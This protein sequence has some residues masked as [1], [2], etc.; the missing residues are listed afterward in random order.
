MSASNRALKIVA[1]TLTIIWITLL[2]FPI[3]WMVIKSL[4]GTTS[5]FSDDVSFML[6]PPLC[7][8]MVVDYTEEQAAELGDEGMYL[9]ASSLVW[10][11]FNYKTSEIGKSQAIVTVDGKEAMSYSLSKA[12]YEIHKGDFSL[13][14]IWEHKD[15]ERSVKAMKEN[16]FMVITDQV[17]FPKEEQTNTYSEKMYADFSEDA[18]ILGNITSC[19]YRK[20]YEN[21]FDHYKIAWAYPKS[22]GINTGL[23]RPILNTLFVAVSTMFLSIFTASLAAY[24]M[25]KLLPY[26]LKD[27][28]MI[29]MMISGMVPGVV[30][31]ISSFQLLQNLGLSNS[32]WSLILP[33]AANWGLMLILKA[34]FDAYPDAVLEAARIDGASEFYLFSR[35]ALPAAKGVLAIQVLQ[36]FVSCWNTYFMANLMIRDQEKYLIGQ[37]IYYMMNVGSAPFETLLAAGFLISV[38]T[39][40]MYA[41][42]Q[43]P[44]AYGIDFSGV[45]G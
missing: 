31:T 8:T 5:E 17:R 35:I 1:G 7:Y 27:K 34:T 42:F 22:M 25:S 33:T 24:A 12:N 19:S 45:K 23:I 36:I 37:I 9:Q 18:D 4:S 2:F 3:Y 29:V 21:I 16:E 44:M 11:M 38:P 26:W 41:I 14:N 43:K 13:R 10:R 40:L 28:V 39:L 20:S 15:V 30:T 32:L 6:K